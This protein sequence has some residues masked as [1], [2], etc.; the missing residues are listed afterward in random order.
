M[1]N[2]NTTPDPMPDEDNLIVRAD[3]LGRLQPALTGR[4]VINAFVESPLAEGPFERLA[5]KSTSETDHSSDFW[6]KRCMI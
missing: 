5:I 1:V 4:D 2:K 3:K 6:K